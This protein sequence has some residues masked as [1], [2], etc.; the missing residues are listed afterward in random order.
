MTEK[1]D[2]TKMIVDYHP[3]RQLRRDKWINL[4]GEWSLDFVEDKIH[5]K[6]AI[7]VPFC[8]ESEYSGV[9]YKEFVKECVYSRFFTCPDRS[10]Y[11][12]VILHFGAVDQ[13]AKI[14]INGKYVGRH[15]GGYTP[16]SFDITDY[17]TVG[18]NE[19]KVKVYDDVTD[20]IPSGKQ[21]EK[22][23][24]YGCFYTRTTGIW[25]TVWLEIVPNDHIVSV[26]YYTDINEPSVDI[27]IKTKDAGKINIAVFF[28]DRMVGECHDRIECDGNFKIK[29]SEKHLWDVGKGNLYDVV[30]T[31]NSDKVYSYFGL[32]SVEYNGRKFFLNGRSVFQRMVLDQGYYNGGVYTPKNFTDFDEDIKRTVKLGFNGV[33]LHQK[34]FDPEYLYYCDK[35]GVMVWGE[36]PSWGIRY[37]DL[38]ALG[39]FTK[40]WT[41]AVERDFN[42]PSIVTW[43][44]LNEVWDNIKDKRIPRDVRFVDAVYELTKAIDPTRPCVDVSGGHHGHRTDLFDFHSY[45]EYETL[46][47]IIDCLENENKLSVWML[48]NEKEPNLTYN[49]DYPVNISEFGG[50]KFS[51]KAGSQNESSDPIRRDY[52][53]EATDDWGYGN[54]ISDEEKFVEQYEKIVNLLLSCEKLSGFCYTQLYDIEQEQNGFYTYTRENKFSKSATDRIRRCNSAVAKI[55]EEKL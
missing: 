26:K 27:A 5:K 31:Y 12:R 24:S 30:I 38:D 40:E 29:L 2:N 22:V 19:L 15:I 45:G 9:A 37:S 16:F 53:V 18:E 44:P 21:S 10:D 20:N 33:R 50:K 28:A 48:Y 43:C 8:L 23:Y 34:V 11:E 46:K 41:E 7:Q 36:F 14:Y 13:E 55:E 4:N 54:S 42:H 49:G 1:A 3:N 25:Q 35:S 32:R 17:I 51:N 39:E 52:V 6:H 47:E